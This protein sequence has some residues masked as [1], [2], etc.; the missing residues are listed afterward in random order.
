M[1]D[2]LKGTKRKFTY[3]LVAL[4][5]VIASLTVFRVSS[6][7]EGNPRATEFIKRKETIERFGPA[8]WDLGKN[9]P[10]MQTESQQNE[11]NPTPKSQDQESN[12]TTL[13]NELPWIG[14]IGAEVLRSNEELRS[15]LNLHWSVVKQSEL[16][17]EARSWLSDEATVEKWGAFVLAPLAEPLSAKQLLQRSYTLDALSEAI[18]WK[19][20]PQRERALRALKEVLIAPRPKGL[21][22]DAARALASEKEEIWTLLKPQL[23]SS[24]EI[25]HLKQTSQFNWAKKN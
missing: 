17:Q 14:N 18:N 1:I 19:Q 12:K 3:F 8:A 23:S 21:G 2:S 7:Q 4:G 24:L 13:S 5:L 20:N 25:Q 11:V 16:E 9:L 10:P 6:P 22:P 15:V